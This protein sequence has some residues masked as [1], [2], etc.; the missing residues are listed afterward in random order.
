MPECL[1]FHITSL[2][3]WQNNDGGWGYFPG[4]KSWLEPTLYALLAI[5]ADDREVFA[6][7][8]ALVGRWQLESGAWR[9]CAAVEEAHWAT[10]LAVTL[11]S[12]AGVYDD[13]F[14]RGVAWLIQSSGSENRPISRVAHLLRPAVVEFDASLNG[15]G[16]QSGTA[17]WIEPTA[18][19][20]LAL[21]RALPQYRS[22]ELDRRV[23]MGERMLLDRRTQD[24]G[25]NYG[26][27]KVLGVDLPS[28]PETTA[29]ALMALDGNTVIDWDLA[30]KVAERHWRQ[31]PS[32]Q[33][34]AWLSGCLLRHRG[35]LPA[36]L[37]HTAAE[38]T[39]LVDDVLLAAIE[40]LARKR[41]LA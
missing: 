29:L 30:L 1:D 3:S 32:R 2:K 13:A 8:W 27:R 6:R 28:Y 38:A 14:R 41:L 18:H 4:K 19:A 10:S 39:P 7:G 34:R 11:H 16:W 12:V 5:G 25:W 40:T 22:P 31:T 23:A 17:S 26:N 36:P 21:K 24:G 33:A 37:E 9:P 20:I 35:K 15:W